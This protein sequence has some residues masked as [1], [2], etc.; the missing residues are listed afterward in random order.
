MVLVSMLPRS[1][2]RCRNDIDERDLD[3]EGMIDMILPGP[4]TG[5]CFMDVARLGVGTV[6]V[7]AM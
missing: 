3:L 2:D 4:E 1:I 7:E 6:V 5:W